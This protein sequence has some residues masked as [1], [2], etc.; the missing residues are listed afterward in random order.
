MP[1]AVQGMREMI[2]DLI[3]AGVDVEDVKDALAEVAKVGAYVAANLA[4]RRSGALVATIRGNRAKGKAVV[5]AGRARVRYAGAINYGWPKRNIRPAHFL[6]K[7]DKVMETRAPEI[8][9]EEIE[10]IFKKYGF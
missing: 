1:V 6:Q 5:T 4:P 7:T 9:E 3:K 2:R 10:K 8:F